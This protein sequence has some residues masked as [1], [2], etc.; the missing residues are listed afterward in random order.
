MILKLL[1]S[2]KMNA[3]YAA[4]KPYIEN[5]G[6]GFELRTNF[7]NKVYDESNS[8]TLKELGLVPTCALIVS[9]K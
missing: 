1:A 4:V 2:D 8:K 3:V 9:L 7:P 5:K 6:K